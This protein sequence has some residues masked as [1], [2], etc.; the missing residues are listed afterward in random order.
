MR[1]V[2]AL[3]ACCLLLVATPAANAIPM[4]Y[5]LK[6]TVETG[7]V[8]TVV[9]DQTSILSTSRESAV[10]NVY[11]GSFGIDSG[12]L[13]ADGFN[14]PA[15]VLFFFIKME[16]NIWSYNAA[17][18]SPYNVFGGFRGP[19]PG[20]PD[21]LTCFGAPSPGFDVMNGAIERLTGVVSGLADIPEVAFSNVAPGTFSAIGLFSAIEASSIPPGGHSEF[22]YVRGDGAAISAITGRMEL[23]RIPEPDTLCILGAGLSALCFVRR[24]HGRDEQPL[25]TKRRAL[26][27]VRMR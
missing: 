21:C 2:T 27:A 19:T 5:G 20:N 14:Q 26:A 7:S 1:H 8:V 22:R 4:N 6:F 13:A 3:T 9:Y 18:D 12:L 10:G 25:Q 15:D 11:F 16:N 17:D 23:Y 24:K